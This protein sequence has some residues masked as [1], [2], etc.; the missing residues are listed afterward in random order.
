M[1]HCVHHR[2]LHPMTTN[3]RTLA[4][5][6][7]AA[8]S[9]L[10]QVAHVPIMEYVHIG[11]GYVTGIGYEM[12]IQITYP[13]AKES[14]LIP[15]KI[16]ATLATVAGDVEIMPGL[17]KWKG[18]KVAWSILDGDYPAFVSGGVDCGEMSG[19]RLRTVLS[20]LAPFSGTEEM[21]N[22]RFVWLDL[23]SGIAWATNKG[24][25]GRMDIAPGGTG[26]V[27]LHPSVCAVIGKVFGGEESVQIARQENRLFIIGDGI[28]MSVN[29][30]E[31]K[32]LPFAEIAAGIDN[33]KWYVPLEPSA[34]VILR[35]VKIAE[36]TLGTCDIT[37]RSHNGVMLLEARNMLERDI[38]L[39]VGET[40]LTFQYTAPSNALT[41][42]LDKGATVFYKEPKLAIK[43]LG[44]DFYGLCM[45]IK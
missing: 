11:G 38:S 19:P 3:A 24:I 17:A 1:V 20:T 41:K 10:P 26:W 23:A 9:A 4:D 27:N 30:S 25:I 21:A 45:P 40:S 31:H 14:I 22:T 18:G 8:A 32:P 15:P 7:A 39:E 29:L 13:E 2:K 36:N 44:E 34:A 43:V 5:A 42:V 16:G 12:G 28:E 6:I 37:L 35:C 33:D